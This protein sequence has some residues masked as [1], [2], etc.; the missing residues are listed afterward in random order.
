M[1]T[2]NRGYTRWL[3]P[4]ILILIVVAIFLGYH[5]QT[6]RNSGEVFVEVKAIQT[7]Q[8]WGYNILTDGRIY[9]H[10][11]FI[12]AIPGKHAFRTEADALKVGKKVISKMALKQMP[13]I[14]IE[15]LREMGI[16]SD[17]L[18]YSR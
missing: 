1:S 3:A 18:V 2:T 9:I 14:T 15:E 11:E 13:N 10:Q 4:V 5:S 6:K 12:P 7:S 16:L 8:G 17:S